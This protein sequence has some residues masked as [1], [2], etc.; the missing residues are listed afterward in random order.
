M[1]L[2]PLHDLVG[3]RCHH[4]VGKG[5]QVGCQQ[6]LAAKPQM[7]GSTVWVM[8]WVLV[9]ARGL[10]WVL[11]V[12]VPEWVLEVA[13]VLV[14]EH[15]QEGKEAQ[16]NLCHP[17]HSNPHCQ[18]NTTFRRRMATAQDSRQKIREVP[19]PEHLIAK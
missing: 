11:V 10:E 2:A 9:L 18:G 5:V 3:D 1:D 19:S 12:V 16:D 13:E 4:Q 6:I 8:E 7:K 15:P 14:L 17:A